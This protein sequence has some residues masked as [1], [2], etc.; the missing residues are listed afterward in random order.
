MCFLKNLYSGE[1]KKS[2]H[3]LTNSQI[4]SLFHTADPRYKNLSREALYVSFLKK[5]LLFFTALM[6]FRIPTKQFSTVYLCAFVNS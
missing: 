2:K 3:G 5:K 4:F 6:Y 1:H